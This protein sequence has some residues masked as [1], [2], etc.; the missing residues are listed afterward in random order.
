M[1]IEIS[2]CRLVV[3]DTLREFGFWRC[4]YVVTR[5]VKSAAMVGWW[6]VYVQREGG[7]REG[8]QL[9]PNSKVK[10]DASTL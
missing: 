9:R 4:D 6:T 3:G 5:V 2:V 1:T 10:I 8:Y 7:G